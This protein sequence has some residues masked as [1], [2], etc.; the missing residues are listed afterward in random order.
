MNL[1]ALRHGNFAAL[2]TAIDD[3]TSVVTALKTYEKDAREDL[4][5]KADKAKWKGVNATVSREFI[6]KTAGE[7]ADALAQATSIRDILKDTRAELVSY[8][9]ELNRAI[10]RGAEK[11]LSVAS[12]PGGGFRVSVSAQPSPPGSEQAVKDLRDELQ[13]ILTKATTSD[14]TASQVLRAIAEQAD[15]GFSGVSYTDR[16]TAAEAMKRADDMAKLAKNPKSMSKSEL[17]EFNR[18]LAKYKDDQLFSAEFATKLGAKGTLQFWTDMTDLHLGAKGAD[19]RQM[20]DFQRNLSMTLATATLSDSDA[21]QSWKKDLINQANVNIAS[22]VSQPNRPVGAYGFQVISSLM[23]HG[24]FDSEFLNDYGKQLLKKDMGPAGS[25]GMGVDDLWNRD[26]NGQAMDLVFGK[27][28]GRDPMVGLM[29]AL[30]H[31]AEA[32]TNTFNDKDVLEHVLKSTLYT[33]D[34][35]ASVG[36]AVEAAVMGFGTGETPAGPLPHSRTQVEIMNNVMHL[37][38]EPGRGASLASKDLGVS[39][40]HMANAYMPE[41]SLAMAGSGSES[42]FLTNSD[43]PGGLDRN[44]TTRFLY[45]VSQNPDGRAGIILGQGTYTAHL[46][47]AHIADPSLFDG[48]TDQAIETI[49]GSAGLIQGIV[50]HANADA[51]ISAGLQVEKEQNDSLKREGDVYKTFGAVGIAAGLA[52]AIPA[53]AGEFAGTAASGLLGGVAGIAVDTLMEGRQAQ[54]ALDESLYKS[55]RNLNDYLD[56]TL[57]L[58]QQSAAEAIDRHHADMPPEAT[59]NL[60]RESLTRAWIASDTVLE[61]THARP[62]A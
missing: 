41:I 59:K 27:G 25:A 46:L 53:A 39:F 21:M 32:A 36:A 29:D 13:S 6:S 44:D 23:H 4:K 1:E 3:W 45:E 11:K 2:G 40:G 7:F 17:E 26:N 58:T 52:Y 35:G 38:A 57:A 34:R 47:E 12:E 9:D 50:G 37:V 49:A 56:S 62:S 30:A 42:I 61:D 60:I 10:G 16:D 18:A 33:A 14:S 51:E 55:G 43:N 24:K 5:A 28:D 20:E 54:G 48:S 15:Y 31:N 19:L 8:R 22:D